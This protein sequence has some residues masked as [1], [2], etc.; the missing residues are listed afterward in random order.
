MG[1]Q[2]GRSTT[3]TSETIVIPYFP[4]KYQKE[5]HDSNAR[6]KL[7]LAGIRGGK[8][9][10]GANET[11]K[12]VF[13][14]QKKDWGIF[15]PTYPMLR[16]ARDEIFKWLP[17]RL[18]TDNN[19][20]ERR[21]YLIG[22][23]VLHFFSCEDPDS[24]R[25]TGLDG[26]WVDE[27]S[28]IRDE[29][30]RII[31]G[32]IAQK[33]GMLLTTTTPR[34]M[35]NWVYEIYKKCIDKID[36]EYFCVKF[37]SVDSPYFPKVEAERLR[38]DYP[39]AFYKQE[40]EADFV[41]EADQVFRSVDNCIGG[42]LKTKGVD[43]SIGGD[44]GKHKDYTVF[45]AIQDGQVIGYERYYKI[46][47]NMQKDRMRHFMQRYQGHALIDSTGVGDPIL[48][49]LQKDGLPVEGYRYTNQSKNNLIS[50]LAIA[51]EN[52]EIT[53]PDIPELIMELKAFRYTISN[54]GN[55]KFGTQSGH[56][57]TVNALALAWWNYK[58]HGITPSVIFSGDDRTFT[59]EM[60]W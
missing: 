23:S 5:F 31:L 30:Y 13:Q 36:P 35:A 12:Q 28:Y 1:E 42:S 33:Q 22:G 19:K 48:D 59:K 46:D 56:D 17:L 44:L 6:F 14:G 60:R 38:R 32:R 53:F 9:V 2:S 52:Q 58:T 24:L 47:W 57:D 10:S 21:V 41:A 4:H 18:I 7:L 15:G 16:V 40:L 11:I 39:E 26:A 25:G 49:D 8:T 37:R 29:A 27:G 3:D 20:G 43:C 50:G 45:F 54:V 51:I 34:G 55:F